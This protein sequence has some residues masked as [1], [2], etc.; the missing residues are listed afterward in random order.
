LRHDARRIAKKPS[1]E[2]SQGCRRDDDRR[3]SQPY[4]D[5]CNACSQ[6]DEGKSFFGKRNA[7]GTVSHISS[8]VGHQL[9]E[10]L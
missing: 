8:A 3:P 10:R 2:E 1:D 4:C 7:Y 6:A 9:R 5:Q